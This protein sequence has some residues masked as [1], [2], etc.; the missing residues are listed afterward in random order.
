M[1]LQLQN[2]TMQLP[3]LCQKQLVMVMY[4]LFPILTKTTNTHL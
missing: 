2:L 4:I 1:P 3:N